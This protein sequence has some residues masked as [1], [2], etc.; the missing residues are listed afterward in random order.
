MGSECGCLPVPEERIIKKWRLQPGKMFLVDLEKGRIIDDKE[1]KDTLASARPYADWIERI[2]VKL[3]EVETEKTPPLKSA[4]P[5]LDRQQ[6]FGYTQEDIKFQLAPMAN[7]G[8]EPVGSMGNDAALAVLSR[9][10]KTLYHYFQ[11][12]FAQ[13][14]NPA[15]DPIREELVT[16]LVSFM[17]PKPTCSAITKEP[18]AS[19]GNPQPV[20]DFFEMEKIRHIDRYNRWQVQVA[21]DRHHLPSAW[22]KEAIEARLASLCA[23]ARDA[24]RAGFRPNHL[25][26]QN[27]R[28]LVAIPAL[29]ALSAIHQHLVNKVCAPAPGFVVETGSAREVHHFA[30]RGPTGPMRCTVPRSLNAARSRRTRRIRGGRGGQESHQELRQGDRQGAEKVMSK[31][32]ISTYMSYTARRS[33]RRGAGAR[34]VDTYFTGRRRRSAASTCSGAD[35][36]SASIRPRSATAHGCSL[37]RSTPAASTLGGCAAKSTLWTPMRLRTAAAARNNAYPTYRNS[38]AL[39][40]DQSQ[41][42]PDVPGL[43]R[44]QVRPLRAGAHR[45]VEPAAEIVKRV[46]PGA[47][48]LG[49]IST[50]AHT[51]LAIA[52]KRIGGKSNTGEGGEDRKRYAKVA[53]G[54]SLM[55]RLG[56]ERVEVDIPL[57]KATR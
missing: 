40:N 34:L 46:S 20:L 50:E 6:A 14:T 11:Q 32:G 28:D 38:A 26:P 41:R 10:N 37:A 5:L 56:H 25:G 31:M 19:A 9:K 7:S 24:V 57:R 49:S 39:V 22:G 17:R 43:F 52:M 18:A 12:L 53:V 16:S 3:D 23:Q 30:A 15:I 1:L 36:A 8:E 21:R 54:E 55:S 35:E 4:V 48:S 27:H 44:V 29:L 33:S 45:E 47:M 51:V 2:R 13:V 42:Q